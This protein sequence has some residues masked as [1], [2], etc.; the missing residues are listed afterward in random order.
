[1]LRVLSAAAAKLRDF[2][3]LEGGG[4]LSAVAG[5]VGSGAAQSAG[6]YKFLDG[7]PSQNRRL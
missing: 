1:V 6:K 2:A 3:R 4:S 7:F 5:A